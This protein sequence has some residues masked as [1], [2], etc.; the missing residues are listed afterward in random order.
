MTDMAQTAPR[1]IMVMAG[2]TGGHVFPA[3]AVASE[4]RD[5]GVAIEWFGTRRGIEAQL[6]PANDF[7]LHFIDVAGV[8]GKGVTTL[9]KA[10]FL[11]LKAVSQARAL[12]L[13]QRP[14]AVLGMG[15]FAS[16]PGGLAARLLGI[17]VVIHEQNAVAGTT[18]RWLA[19]LAR[20]VMEAF[21]GSLPKGD[22][23][24]N[25]VRREI[26][27]LP[28]PGQR[29]QRNGDTPN[30]LVLGGSLGAQAINEVLPQAIARLPRKEWPNIWHQTG[31]D[32][33]VVTAEAYREV[34]VEAHVVPF[35]DDMAEAYGWAD[36]VLCRAGA[37]TVSELAAAGVGSILIPFPHAIDDHQTK[38]GQWLVDN[39]AARQIQQAQLSPEKL[40]V[41]LQQLLGE[42]Q[43]LITM[44]EN[45]RAL[46]R[47]GAICAVA[48]ACEE[49]C[50]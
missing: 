16:G 40:A 14:N 26:I 12:L 32:K 10:P 20:R 35:I 45:A 19:K 24:G 49:V 18:N 7:P 25:P 13:Q 23:C 36:L 34:G 37:L 47:P 30:L 11:L 21:P 31:R 46:A 15:G 22:H 29:L 44:A 43:Q 3:L 9:L 17:P 2:G 50:K 27:D 6:V 39:N 42:R 38:N 8:R 1:K 48:D 28:E 4:L 41:E 33:A 5:R